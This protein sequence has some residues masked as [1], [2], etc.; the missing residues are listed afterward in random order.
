MTTPVIMDIAAAAVLLLFL[1]IGAYQGF[2]RAIAGLLITVVALVGA[3]MLSAGLADPM[4]RMLAPVIE[5]KIA[6]EVEDAVSEHTGLMDTERNTPALWELMEVLGIDSDAWEPI[7]SRAEETMAR[8]GATVLSAVVESLTRSVVYAGLFI[9]SFIL[10]LLLLHILA[11]AMDLLTRLPGLHALN[12][13]GGA[14]TGLMK[15]ALALFLAIWVLR[16]L[17]VSFETDNVS[18]TYILQFFATHTPL[19]ALSLLQ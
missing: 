4:T 15:G 10:L 11:R 18:Q 6:H 2:V 14:A 3:A 8:T 16:R 19:S 1:V 17:G 13:L 7:A 5:E 9:L 12:A